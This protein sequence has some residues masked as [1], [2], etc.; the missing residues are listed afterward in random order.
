M[1]RYELFKT[2]TALISGIS[3]FEYAERGPDLL[4]G[5]NK[6]ALSDLNRPF[7]ISALA[8]DVKKDLAVIF[9]K[10]G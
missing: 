3:L 6:T 5:T 7:I 1:S 8:T 2:K 10:H 4:P 9:S